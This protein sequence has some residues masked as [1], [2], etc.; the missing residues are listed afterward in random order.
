MNKKDYLNLLRYH[1]GELPKIVVD[2]IIYDYEEHF[3]LGIEQGKTEEKI[4]EEL[5]YPDDIAKEY[6]GRDPQ[7]ATKKENIE[8]EENIEKNDNRSRNILLIVLGLIFA[9]VIIGAITG[10]FGLAFGIFMGL[11]GAGVGLIVGG[12][13]LFLSFFPFIP[14]S[15]V[16]I[17]ANPITR[18][19]TGIALICFGIILLYLGI[20][21][22]KFFI[23]T[24]GDVFFAIRWK[25][26]I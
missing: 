3:N 16:A 12:L 10:I 19:F 5:G 21:F 14:V 4:A 11:M 24:V 6:L 8:N 17:L 15:E 20:K 22:L 2:D 25:L 26:V 18:L 9:P 13:G 23:R 1:L 7:K